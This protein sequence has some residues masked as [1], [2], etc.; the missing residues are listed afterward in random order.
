MKLTLNKMGYATL[1]VG[2][3]LS[4]TAR[5]MDNDLKRQNALEFPYGES[6]VPPTVMTTTTMQPTPTSVSTA[7]AAGPESISDGQIISVVGAA[8]DAEIG[9]AS[10]AKSRGDSAE[11]RAFA[12]HMVDDHTKNKVEE[13][14]LFGRQWDN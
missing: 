11:V 2:S 10:L 6:A 7:A 14:T 3:L 1:I 13:K 4:L 8:N 5:G 12:R 9:A